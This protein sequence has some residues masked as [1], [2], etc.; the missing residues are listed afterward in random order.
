MKVLVTGASGFLGSHI[1]DACIEKGFTVRVIVRPT[2][3]CCYLDTLGNQ[4]EQLKGDFNDR[5]FINQALTDIDTVLHSAA[6]VTDVG[7]WN[8]F[9]KANIE[10]T[11][12]LLTCAQLKKVKRFVFVSSPSVVAEL[13]DQINIDERYPY[14]SRF[15][16]YYCET[17]A[18]AEQSVLN[19]NTESFITC[20]IRPRGIWGPRDVAGPF[21]KFLKKMKLGRLKNLSNGRQIQSS[22]CYVKNAADACV[23]AAI[24]PNVAG[25]AYFITDAK[26]I[27]IWPFTDRLAD[28]FNIPRVKG[29]LPNGLIK[30]VVPLVELIWRI[31]YLKNHIAPPVSHYVVGLVTYSA[32]Y[33]ISRAKRDLNYTPIVSLDEGIQQFKDWV[34]S[35]GGID[36]YLDKMD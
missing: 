14:P 23:K 36:S 17:K 30:A 24:S 13:R 16:N 26:P 4:I 31:P 29:S 22:V 32:T 2:S 1:V 6:R 10:I 35:V 21:A 18:I 9:Y 19:A 5:D 12:Q 3:D 8:L 28:L 20:A 27:D 25:K 11:E 33:D 34:E 15:L 7:H